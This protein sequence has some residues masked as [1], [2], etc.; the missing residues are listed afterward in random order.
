MKKIAAPKD[1]NWT[2]LQY[3]RTLWDAF[4]GRG[5]MFISEHDKYDPQDLFIIQWCMIGFLALA[6]ILIFT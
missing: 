2:H 4:R 5:D 1:H 3:P 6:L